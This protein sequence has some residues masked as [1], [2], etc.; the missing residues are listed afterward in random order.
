M[1]PIGQLVR[2]AFHILISERP[3]G[4]V[5]SAQRRSGAVAFLGISEGWLM[6]W[7]SLRTA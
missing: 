5:V 2:L 7:P 6:R 3:T 1:L 4:L